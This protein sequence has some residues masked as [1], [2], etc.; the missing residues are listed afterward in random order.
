M[1]WEHV[2]LI[3]TP[4]IS[5]IGLGIGNH[6]SNRPAREKNKVDRF[7]KIMQELDRQYERSQARVEE[8]EERYSKAC[9]EN[10]ALRRKIKDLRHILNRLK[11]GGD[12]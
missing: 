11:E 10:R 9:E 5:A 8:C 12:N 4:I 2:A 6:I 3:V 7:E 1:D